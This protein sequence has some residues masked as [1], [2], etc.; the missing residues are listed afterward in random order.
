MSAAA[1][2]QVQQLDIE[3]AVRDLRK[4]SI[5]AD[6][7]EDQLVWLAEHCIIRDYKAGEVMTAEGDP[8]DTMFAMITGEL[9]GKRETHE[10]GAANAWLFLWK[11]GEIA[12]TVPFSRMKTWPLTGRAMV[13][14]RAAVFHVGVFSEMLARIPVLVERLVH[15]MVDRARLGVRDEEQNQSLL[16]LGKIAA[17]LAHELYNPTAAVQRGA[18]ELRQ[19]F[20][21][22]RQSSIN[23]A[24][25]N[26]HDDALRA[27]TTI[28]QGKSGHARALDPMARSERIELLGE[29]LDDHRVQR[30]W[31][32]AE[33]FLDAGIEVAELEQLAAHFPDEALGDGLIWLDAVLAAD[34]LLQDVESATARVTGLVDAV[35]SYSYMDRSPERTETDLH[36][37][38][39]DTLKIL[40]HKLRDKNITVTRAYDPEL[41]LAIVHAGEMNQVWTNLLDNAIDA[42]PDG[43]QIT[44]RTA[45]E[46]L[47]ILVEIIDN[48]AGITQ[49]KLPRIWEPFYTTKDVGKGTGLGLDIVRRI[50]VR[51]HQGEIRVESVPGDTRFQVRLPLT[52]V[53]YVT[54]TPGNS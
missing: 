19:R 16:A 49:D 13:P 48:G 24:H 4:V 21:D 26:L 8:A 3:S 45:R 28:N 20:Q 31:T 40:T 41:P 5:F 7:E 1:P 44:V 6:L 34:S 25:H 51:R 23:L 29:W 14:T 39:D 12:G 17:G 38:L 2:G 18:R 52:T 37:A 53:D 42:A 9:R 30:A 36:A 11:A 47:H 10:H 22:F 35:K 43:G 32:L 27:L 15:I 50:V 33:S 54:A 46:S